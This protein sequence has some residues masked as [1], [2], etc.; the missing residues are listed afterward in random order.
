[1]K[2][3]KDVLYPLLPI[4]VQYKLMSN[5]VRRNYDYGN[6]NEKYR[7]KERKITDIEAHIITTFIIDINYGEVNILDFG[8]GNGS[9]YDTFMLEQMMVPITGIDISKRQIDEAKA[10][11]KDGNWICADFMKWIPD[12]KY[13]G[14]TSFYSFYNFPRRMWKQVLEKMYNILKDGG[15]VLINIRKEDVGACEYHSEWCGAPM[16]FSYY[17]AEK[18]EKIARSVGF[19]VRR[20]EVTNNEEYN[21][22]ILDKHPEVRGTGYDG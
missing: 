16:V 22:Y 15:G 6:Y 14:I 12:K 9:L 1:M 19:E 8:C 10:N 2:S 18:F 17:S 5:I 21:W 11:I 4:M 20:F 3:I 7:S 13:K